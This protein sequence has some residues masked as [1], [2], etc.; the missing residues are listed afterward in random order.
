MATLP[1]AVALA[2]SRIEATT[3][4]PTRIEAVLEP[5][6]AAPGIASSAAR[7]TAL[8]TKDLFVPLTCDWVAMPACIASPMPSPIGRN[9][10]AITSGT[11]G[12]LTVRLAGSAGRLTAT[13]SRTSYAAAHAGVSSAPG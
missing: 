5:A 7:R 11:D 9:H 13:A 4:A 10:E 12:V 6:I 1:S 2:R 8:R 3:C